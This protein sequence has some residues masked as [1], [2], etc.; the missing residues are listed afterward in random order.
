MK[1]AY[2]QPLTI[3]TDLQLILP[4]NA[5]GN[6]TYGTSEEDYTAGKSRDDIEDEEESD[7][8]ANGLW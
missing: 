5:T 6:N 4:F 1:K 2:I 3:V 7:E 8:W